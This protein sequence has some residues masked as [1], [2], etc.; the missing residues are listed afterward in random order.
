M[1]RTG[2][3]PASSCGVC[4]AE[5]RIKLSQMS[6]AKPEKCMLGHPTK[7]F[8]FNVTLEP[9]HDKVKALYE[10]FFQYSRWVAEGKKPYYQSVDGKPEDRQY[11]Y[12]KYH[13]NITSEGDGVFTFSIQL[14]DSPSGDTW[15]HGKFNLTKDGLRIIEEETSFD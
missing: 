15:W 10:A 8:K 5:A 4:G 11:F 14:S 13:N 6:E 2:V 3:V 1:D 9:P 12:D 7:S